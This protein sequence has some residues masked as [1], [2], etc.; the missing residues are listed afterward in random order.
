MG[1]VKIETDQYPQAILRH[2]LET[3][4]N[5]EF[6][7][8][9]NYPPAQQKPFFLNQRILNFKKIFFSNHPK[10]FYLRPIYSIWSHN[11]KMNNFS[12]QFPSVLPFWNHGTKCYN[13]ALIK[14]KGFGAFGIFFL[15]LWFRKKCFCCAGG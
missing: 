9:Q 15:T 6:F 5:S 2:I 1:H 4:R 8:L 11:S 14:K 3:S 13:L 12:K 7:L 10:S